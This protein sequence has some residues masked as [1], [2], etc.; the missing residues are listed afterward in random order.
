VEVVAH[1]PYL[2]KEPANAAGVRL[3]GFAEL[4]E[5]SDYVIIQAPLTEETRGLFDEATIAQMKPGAVLINTSRG[6]IVDSEALCGALSSGHLAGA[7]LDDL[8]EE[9]AKQAH[10]TPNNPLFEQVDCL[11]T[12]HVAYYSEESIRYART[13]AANEVVRVLQGQ[14]PRSPVN[15]A[16]LKANRGRA[17]EGD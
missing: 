12:P 3:V 8:A 5:T 10:W 16:V 4:I 11:I 7:A 13:Y 6:P 9:P 15:P 1:D 17:I 14:P 2:D